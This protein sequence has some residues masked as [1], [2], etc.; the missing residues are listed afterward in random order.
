[1]AI[2]GDSLLMMFLALMLINDPE[3]ARVSIIGTVPRPNKNIYNAPCCG[4][5]VV[6]APAKA[7]YTNPQGRMPFN[8]PMVN[9]E[10]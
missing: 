1:M 9:K 8:K 4:P 6:A 10:L 3:I 5:C 7:R 2:T